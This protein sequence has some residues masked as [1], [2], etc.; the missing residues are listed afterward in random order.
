MTRMLY[1]VDSGDTERPKYARVRTVPI[2]TT[3]SMIGNI[4]V[5]IVDNLKNTP[6]KGKT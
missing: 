6:D 1:I 4:D 3:S 2:P 5:T